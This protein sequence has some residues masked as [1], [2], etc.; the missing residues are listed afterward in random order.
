MLC[1]QKFISYINNNAVNDLRKQ[2][3]CQ[4]DSEASAAEDQ[5]R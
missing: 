4:V 2:I 5:I 1:N 3:R